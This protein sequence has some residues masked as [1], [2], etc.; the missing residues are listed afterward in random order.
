VIV[1]GA[2]LAD[3]L[4]GGRSAVG[5]QVRVQGLEFEVVG[6]VARRGQ[7]LGM[8]L[9]D[10]AAVPLG[11]LGARRRDSHFV[12]V[13]AIPLVP[14]EE[15][16]LVAEIRATLRA[17]RRLRRDVADDFATW[18]QADLL[19]FYADTTRTGR[20]LLVGLSLAGLLVGG[21]GIMNVMLVAVQTRRHEIGVRRALGAR[22]R[23]ILLQFLAEAAAVSGAGG[24]LGLCLG[25]IAS[26]SIAVFTPLP[27]TISLGWSIL[28][29]LSAVGTGLVFGAWPASRAANLD[30]VAALKQS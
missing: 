1:L 26:F 28:A 30:P 5:R 29:F 9:D 14:G 7:L 16:K 10:F 2:D 19:E 15:A 22:R 21:I 6:V 3:R 27:T 18:T 24:L 25:W 11:S 17:V 4:F 13:V 12:D 8:N 20:A 23:Q